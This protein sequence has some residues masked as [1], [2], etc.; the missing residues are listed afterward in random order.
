MGGGG[1]GEKEY[2]GMH[3]LGGSLNK[4]FLYLCICDFFL[5]VIIIEVLL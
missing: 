5:Y 1:G 3:L 2:W 4:I